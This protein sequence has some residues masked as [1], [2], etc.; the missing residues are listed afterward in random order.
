MAKKEKVNVVTSDKY[1]RFTS[2]AGVVK[3]GTKSKYASL[4]AKKM[5]KDSKRR[6]K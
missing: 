2:A 1:D 4:S 3:A 6:D 5:K